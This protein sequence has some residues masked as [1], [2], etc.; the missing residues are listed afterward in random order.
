MATRDAH[1]GMLFHSCCVFWLG[2]ATRPGHVT[3]TFMLPPWLKARGGATMVKHTRSAA[4]EAERQ[5]RRLVVSVDMLLRLRLGLPVD[6]RLQNS[7]PL[8]LDVCL[9]ILRIRAG[10]TIDEAHRLIYTG[11]EP[12]ASRTWE[13][14]SPCTEPEQ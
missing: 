7:L 13:E 11:Y 3:A 1:H 2:V 10:I 9:E 8:S 5:S 6:P 4:A 12:N 14:L